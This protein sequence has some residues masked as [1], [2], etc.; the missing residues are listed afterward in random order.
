M[1]KQTRTVSTS[2]NFTTLKAGEL[3]R[4]LQNLPEDAR[5]YVTKYAG[6]QRDPGYSTVKVTWQEE[7]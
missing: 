6:D 7:F 4:F 1:S 2:M 3:R 5:V